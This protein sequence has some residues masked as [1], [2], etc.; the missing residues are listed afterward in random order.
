MSANKGL[1]GAAV[2]VVAVGAAVGLA[3]ERYAIGRTRL[4]VDPA[5]GEPFFALPADRT[6]RVVADDGVPLHV[7]EVGPASAPLTVVFVH[8]YVQE[9]AVW[10]F[11]RRALAADNPGRLVFYDH[12]SHGRSGRG[13]P[14]SA[15][16]DQ[17]GRDLGTVLDA[18][19]PRGRIVLVGHSMGGMTILALAEARPELYRS[20]VVGVALIGTSTGKLAE[21]TFGLPAAMRPVT[22]RVLPWL[23]RGMRTVPRPF[24]RGRRVGTDLAFLVLRF[25]GFGD[26]GVSPA[27][28]EFVEQMFA[29]MPVEV[30]AEFYDTFTTH[31]KLRAVEVLRGVQ[32]LVLV[33]SKDLVTPIEH[34]R[35][36]AAALPDAHLVEVEGAGH[37]VALERPELVTLQLRA[38]LRRATRAAARTA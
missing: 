25:G 35:A 26:H 4:R 27:V 8:G 38:L 5:A 29:R 24:E 28:V 11:Q 10:H 23:T 1:L 3:A 37:M 7:E 19:A 12:R 9:M 18:V 20:R 34:S 17:L 16:I 15:T 2:G 30:I 6:R 13:R 22:R 21:L 32:T 36:I 33:G 14:E 31:D